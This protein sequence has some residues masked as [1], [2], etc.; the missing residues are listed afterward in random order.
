MTDQ[1]HGDEAQD[2]VGTGAEIS[3]ENEATAI[4]YD[5]SDGVP[6]SGAAPRAPAVSSH[7]SEAETKASA[8]AAEAAKGFMDTLAELPGGVHQSVPVVALDSPSAKSASS[9]R[10]NFYLLAMRSD[11]GWCCVCNGAQCR[12]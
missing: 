1:T 6:P 4:F 10:L 9:R 8:A 11:F 7:S 2:N 3:T 12:L 5:G